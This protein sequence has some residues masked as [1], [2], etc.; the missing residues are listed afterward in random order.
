MNTPN[1]PSQPTTFIGRT[2][3]LAEIA[4]LLADPACRLLTLVGAGGI[5]KTRLAIEAAHQITRFEDIHFVALQH[6][7][8]SHFLVTSIAEAI[9]FRLYALSDPKQQL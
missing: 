6:L 9:D 4:R 3:E 1:L 5:G 7:T 8:S 2:D